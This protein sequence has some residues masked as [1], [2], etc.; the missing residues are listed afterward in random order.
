M[1]LE[2][3]GVTRLDIETSMP[4]VEE[5]AVYPDV[6]FDPSAGCIWMC[7]ELEL[8]MSSVAAGAVQRYVAVR[9]HERRV[10]RELRLG[11]G[12]G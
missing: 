1:P 2:L 12:V 4:G 6:P 7:C 11:E 3:A 10:L 9:G 8:A 5:S